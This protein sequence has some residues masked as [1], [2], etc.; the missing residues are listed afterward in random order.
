MEL[1]SDHFDSRCAAVARVV[2]EIAAHSDLCTVGVLLL[3]ANIYT[4]SCVRKVAFA[5]AWNVLTADEIDSVS[6]FAD[7]ENALR[8][9]SELLCVAYPTVPCTWDSHEGAA[10]P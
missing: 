2:E 9:T 10:F 7:S 8:K 6:T 1:D 4:D 5:V 3:R